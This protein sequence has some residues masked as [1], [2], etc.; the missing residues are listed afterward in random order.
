MSDESDGSSG[1][2]IGSGPASS[3]VGESSVAVS[4]GQL[5]PWRRLAGL[6]AEFVAAFLR[7]DGRVRAEEELIGFFSV[8]PEGVSQAQ[9]VAVILSEEEQRVAEVA[10]EILGQQLT[11]A[12]GRA[13]DAFI[14]RCIYTTTALY[15]I[16]C[17]LRDVEDIEGADMV[18]ELVERFA[19]HEA[20]TV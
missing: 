10:A 2:G 7:G 14:S 17:W 20:K 18:G 1:V 11:D 15:A 13:C 5:R 6:C 12:Q 4:P 19:A 8:R 9:A 3:G 16:E